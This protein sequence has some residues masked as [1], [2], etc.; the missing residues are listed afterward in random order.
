MSLC[1]KIISGRAVFA[2]QEENFRSMRA[3]FRKGPAP[4]IVRVAA[5]SCKQKRRISR[6]NQQDMRRN[7]ISDK[8]VCYM[9]FWM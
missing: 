8:A 4:A 2:L 7:D 1:K 3:F 9:N 5:H 6:S